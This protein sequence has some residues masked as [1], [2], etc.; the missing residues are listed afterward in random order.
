MTL[1][2]RRFHAGLGYLKEEFLD[3]EEKF[4]LLL[5]DS[6]GEVEFPMLGRLEDPGV[7]ELFDHQL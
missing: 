4:L 5:V 7:A 1:L 6:E 2:Q 3:F